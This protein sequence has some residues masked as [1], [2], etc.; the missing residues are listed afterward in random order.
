MRAAAMS[1]TYI[2]AGLALLPVAFVI[3]MAMRERRPWR[4][5]LRQIREL[6]EVSRTQNDAISLENPRG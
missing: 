3:A 2:A 6:P 1:N 4:H 5:Q